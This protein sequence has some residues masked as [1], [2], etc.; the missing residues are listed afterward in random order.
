M[1]RM[2]IDDVRNVETRGDEE[3][4]GE[5]LN[6]LLLKERRKEKKVPSDK[7]V[8]NSEIVIEKGTRELARC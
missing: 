1:T 2:T 5:K 6:D 4:I 3:S 7:L 8:E